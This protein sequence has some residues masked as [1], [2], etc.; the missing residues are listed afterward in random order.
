MSIRIRVY[1]IAALFSLQ[2]P[3]SL[4]WNIENVFQGM[5]LNVS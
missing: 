3:V 5:S 4:A 1:V 2:A